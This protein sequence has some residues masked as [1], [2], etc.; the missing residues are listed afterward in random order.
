MLSVSRAN[1]AEDFEIAAEFCR[2][3]AE[4]DAVEAPAYGIS[5]EMVVALFH[6]DTSSSLAAKYNSADATMLIARWEGSPAGCLAIDPF[7]EAAI[8][9]HRFY[10]DPRF[11]G[12]GIGG[13][14]IRAALAEVEK[15]SRRTI[16][17]HTAV[18]MKNAIS[19]YESFQFTRCPRFRPTPD[20]V[21]HTDV[22]MSRAI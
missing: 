20:S 1:C 21:S 18:H 7:D 4:W 11:R 15:G 13:A 19:V 16:V 12:R 9:L 2:A 14:L 8:E 10:V 22:F 5:P 6:G 3:I 17:I